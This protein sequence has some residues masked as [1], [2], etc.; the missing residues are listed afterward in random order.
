MERLNPD[1]HR[2]YLSWQ[3]LEWLKA[4]SESDDFVVL[5]DGDELEIRSSKFSYEE[6]IFDPEEFTDSS[7]LLLF[8]NKYRAFI[9]KKGVTNKELH[10]RNKIMILR[11]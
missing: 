1:K 9:W 10:I 11:R 8:C 6:S 4:K 2:E 3:I 7:I 5:F